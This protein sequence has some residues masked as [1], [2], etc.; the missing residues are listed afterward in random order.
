MYIFLYAVYTLIYKHFFFFTLNATLCSQN[1]MPTNALQMVSCLFFALSRRVCSRWRKWRLG[2]AGRDLPKVQ[3]VGSNTT[4]EQLTDQSKRRI[5]SFVTSSRE[6]SSVNHFHIA[7]ANSTLVLADPELRIVVVPS[8]F[9]P[10]VFR[11]LRN[12]VVV[13]SNPIVVSL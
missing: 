8:I 11:E 1:F 9:A 4:L 10:C 12:D 13:V 6:E 7:G 2:R 5:R 3:A